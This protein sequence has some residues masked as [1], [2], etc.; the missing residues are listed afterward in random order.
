[1]LNLR[2]RLRGSSSHTRRL[3]LAL[4]VTVLI[5]GAVAL[6]S[7]GGLQKSDAPFPLHG[8]I[9]LSGALAN[10]GWS[11][12]SVQREDRAGLTLFDYACRHQVTQEESHLKLVDGPASRVAFHTPNSA[13]SVAGLYVRHPETGLLTDADGG[14]Q[15]FLHATGDEVFESGAKRKVRV[16]WTWWTNDNWIAPP[17]PQERALVTGANRKAYL[18]LADDSRSERISPQQEELVRTVLWAWGEGANPTRGDDS[19]NRL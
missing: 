11:V 2:S 7:T 14:R 5:A 19:K 17:S 10:T 15:S 8:R 4:C 16:L 1:M 6:V 12:I 13:T 3:F 9:A 18:V